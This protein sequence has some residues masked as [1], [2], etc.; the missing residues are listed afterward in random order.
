MLRR[1]CK[2]FAIGVSEATQF[3]LFSTF[4]STVCMPSSRFLTLVTSPST[5]DRIAVQS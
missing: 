5:G 1:P 4:T 3:L 2:R